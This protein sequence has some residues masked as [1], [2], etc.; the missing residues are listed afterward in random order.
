VHI[1]QDIRELR[2]VA[3]EELTKNK[4]EKV[5]ILKALMITHA[6]AALAFTAVNLFKNINQIF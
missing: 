4:P 6:M 2:K 3:L 1:E 5:I